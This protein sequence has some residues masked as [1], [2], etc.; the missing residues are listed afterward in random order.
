MEVQPQGGLVCD[1]RGR[2]RGAA[3]SA[4]SPFVNTTSEPK[5]TPRRRSIGSRVTGERLQHFV[6]RSDD[7]AEILSKVTSRPPEYNIVHIWGEGGIGKTTLLRHLLAFIPSTTPRG[8]ADVE[9][10]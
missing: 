4:G 3:H 5:P 7:V 2:G 9:T 6:G 1:D 10:A 8:L